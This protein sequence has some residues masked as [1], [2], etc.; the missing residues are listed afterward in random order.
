MLPATN[1][2]QVCGSWVHMGSEQVDPLVDSDLGVEP[3]VL[4]GLPNQNQMLQLVG[5]VP[6]AM[7][8]EQLA[9]R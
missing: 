5:N 4:G 6:H 1:R 3:A 9:S 7:P 8:C 2:F